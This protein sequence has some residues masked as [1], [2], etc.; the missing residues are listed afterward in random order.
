[1]V[2]CGMSNRYAVKQNTK[3]VEKYFTE[4]IFEERSTEDAGVES[5]LSSHDEVIHTVD[6]RE[7]QG[8]F[9]VTN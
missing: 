8:L 2:Y 1:M 3:Y 4:F 9:P 6:Y 5:F 7:C